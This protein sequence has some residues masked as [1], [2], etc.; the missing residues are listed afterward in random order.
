MI[1]R[2]KKGGI[3][4]EIVLIV[5]LMV[6]LIFQTLALFFVICVSIDISMF[7]FTGLYPN[8]V[9]KLLRKIKFEWL[10]SKIKIHMK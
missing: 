9:S 7:L 1:L 3:Y 2:N 4:L 5:L 8:L 10:S 6:Y